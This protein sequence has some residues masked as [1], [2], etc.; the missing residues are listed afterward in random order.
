MQFGDFWH[1]KA[2]RRNL[3][4]LQSKLLKEKV[5]KL[6]FML[7]VSVFWIQRIIAKIKDICVV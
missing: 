3:A 2:R 5:E 6:F 4:V 7:L 1:L